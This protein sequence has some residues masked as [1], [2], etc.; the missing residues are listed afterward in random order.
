MGV[1][2]GLGKA[3]GGLVMGVGGLMRGVAGGLGRFVRR[4]F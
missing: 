2:R 1:L 3:L 4:L